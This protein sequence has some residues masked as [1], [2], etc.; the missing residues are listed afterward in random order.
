MPVGR[1][2]LSVLDDQDG[3]ECPSYLRITTDP[4]S[5]TM[6]FLCTLA[7][8]AALPCAALGQGTKTD[9]PI[10]VIKIELKEPISYDKHIEPIFYKRCTVCHSGNVKEGKFDIS[11]YELL[12]KGGKS[13][14]LVKPGKGEES[15]LY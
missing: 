13:G 1:T 3:Q 2:F 7:V 8:V 10:K 14:E 4:W 11:T 6:R 12:M 9:G 15:I 5:F